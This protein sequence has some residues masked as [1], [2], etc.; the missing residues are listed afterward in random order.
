MPNNA[1]R[2]LWINALLLAAWLL[3]MGTGLLLWALGSSQSG[4]A[5]GSPQVLARR[6]WV[7]IHQWAGLGTLPVR[8]IHAVLHRRWISRVGARFFVGLNPTGRRKFMVVAALIVTFVGLSITGLMW[9][10]HHAGE[11]RAEARG[12]GS[13]G[14]FQGSPGQTGS[15]QAIRFYPPDEASDTAARI[16]NL[17][18][19]SAVA[20]GSLLSIHLIQHRKWMTNAL[21]RRALIRVC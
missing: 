7:E 17:H 12:V 19:W 21:L 15:G 13:E 18:R 2:H 11:T 10:P 16:T 1:N 9:L 8:G 5:G 3:A 14:R 4:D 20:I 6:T